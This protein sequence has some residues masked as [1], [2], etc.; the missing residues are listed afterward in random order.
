MKIKKYTGAGALNDLLDTIHHPGCVV[1][2]GGTDILPHI[3]NGLNNY[4]TLVSAAQVN[5]LKKIQF[6]N[7]MVQI[8]ASVT[9][10]ELIENEKLFNLYPIIRK[11]ISKIGAPQH[12]Y[13]GTI[14]GNLCLDTRCSYYN[15]SEFWR[16]ALGYCLK[17]KGDKCHVVP[18]S[19]RCHA[20]MSSDGVALFV[21]LE[22][23]IIIQSQNNKRQIQLEDLYK[24]DGMNHLN[25]SPN[26]LITHI[27][28]P[29]PKK[30]LRS[31]YQKLRVR[32]SFD[33]PLLGMATTLIVENE[34]I[35][36]LRFVFT[37]VESWPIVITEKELGLLGSTI[38]EINVEEVINHCKKNCNPLNNAF[39]KAGWR[40]KMIA[41][42]IKRFFNNLEPIK[43][44]K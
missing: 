38:S 34:K 15:Q 41:V 16:G 33:F 4:D 25:L 17:F 36:K 18:N 22:A 30:N 29:S 32:K 2:G 3:K 13:S 39:L 9:L 7:G 8:G 14:G 37:A 43:S 10:Q 11:A 23:E 35:D 21:A 40:R 24:K 44:N 12:R 31:D 6:E 5:D 20:I 19:D 27:I 42:F 26:E 28:L 1:L